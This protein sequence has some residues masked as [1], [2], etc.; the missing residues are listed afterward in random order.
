M[1]Q[2]TVHYALQNEVLVVKFAGSL[3]LGDAFQTSAAAEQLF[4]R[5]FAEGGFKHVALD[6]TE[7]ENLDS[8]N[9]GL[10][11]GVA[12]FTD[13]VLGNKPT[14]FS[15]NPDITSLLQQVGLDS[16][17][18]MVNESPKNEGELEQVTPT[19]A[20]E[21]DFSALVLEAHRA[22]AALND[23]NRAQFK[24]VLEVFEREER[25]NL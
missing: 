19:D 16:V 14:L 7:T 25:G 4:A 9:L 17:F 24:N 21:T 2:G 5:L 13:E 8:T 20:L 1:S 18:H 12:R 3:C 22:L 6:L 23:A 10:L 11:A 15:T